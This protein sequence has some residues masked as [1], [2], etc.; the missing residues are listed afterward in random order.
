MKSAGK[1]K[2]SVQESICYKALQII[3]TMFRYEQGYVDMPP[4]ERLE[5]RKRNV[6]PLVVRILCVS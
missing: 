1:E 3:Q 4:E 5:Q 6:A 2:R